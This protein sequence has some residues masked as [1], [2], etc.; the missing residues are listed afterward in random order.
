MSAMR[1]TRAIRAI[2][3]ERGF[4]LT[5][6]LVVMAVLGIVLAGV[7]VI[8][9]QGTQSYLIGASRVE[10]QQNARTTLELMVRELRSAQS[11]TALGGASD[12]SFVDQTG[13]TIRYQL[14]GTTLNRSVNGTAAALVGGVQTLTLTYYSAFDGSTNTGTVTATPGNVKVIRIAIITGSERGASTGSA[15]DQHATLESTVRLRNS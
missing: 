1:A 3:N 11:V 7:F 14:V 13:A 6:L 8:Q 12:V 4:T 15:G 2:R 5:E 9:Q 10:V